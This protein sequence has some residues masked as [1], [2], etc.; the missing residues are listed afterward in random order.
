MKKAFQLLLPCL[1][2]VTACTKDNASNRNNPGGTKLHRVLSGGKVSHEYVYN[3][4]GLVTRQT[5]YGIGDKKSVETTY[6]YDSDNKLA[7]TES[8]HDLSSSTLSQ[9]LEYGYTEF[10]YGTDGR[11]TE[12][13]IYLKTGPQ[14]EFK[15]KVNLS[16]DARGRIISR[17]LSSPD[18]KPFNLH[19]YEYNNSGNIIVEESYRYEGTTQILSFRRSYEHDNENNPYIN[20]GVM[21]FSVN[22]NNITKLTMTNYEV[23]PGTPVITSSETIYKKYNARGLPV[24]VVEHGTVTFIYEYR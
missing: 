8:M 13:K 10:K 3:E 22:R 16:Y 19:N 9:L 12:E 24:E 15:S 21:P 20:L 14:F 23:T 18:D 7:R 11:L 17:L 6:Q 5:F 4:R 1:L 2:I